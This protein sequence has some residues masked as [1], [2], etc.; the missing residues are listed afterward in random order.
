MDGGG[1]YFNV[2]VDDELV[3]VIET[4]EGFGVYELCSMPFGEHTLV[5]HKRTE[6]AVKTALDWFEPVTFYGLFVD[7]DSEFNKVGALILHDFKKPLSIEFIG[8]SDTTSFG[9]EG[10]PT[11]ADDI[12]T[13]DPS[14]QNCWNSYAAQAAR[15]FDVDYHQVCWTGVGVVHGA[16]IPGTSLD[17]IQRGM[18]TVYPRALAN[19]ESNQPREEHQL[20]VVFIG[21]NDLTGEDTEMFES[22]TSAGLKDFLKHYEELLRMVRKSNPDATILCVAPDEF[23]MSAE[24]DRDGQRDTSHL[25]QLAVSK[26]VQDCADPNVHY[27]ILSPTIQIEDPAK[28]PV[29]DWAMLAHWSVK[30]HTKVAGALVAAI[31]EVTGWEIISEPTP[32]PIMKPVNSVISQD[33]CTIS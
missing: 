14:K 1:N 32:C 8:D 25:V 17:V 13:M 11:G 30:G 12:D 9:N 4:M 21:G 3:R 20:C 5:L 2:F 15:C 6:A 28:T 24:P 33:Q 19:S 31:H 27:R 26:A 22:F 10:E 7:G 16:P 23:T 18:R 29:E